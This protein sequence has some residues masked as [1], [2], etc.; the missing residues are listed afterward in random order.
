VHPLSASRC[1]VPALCHLG[2]RSI[3]EPSGTRLARHSGIMPSSPDDRAGLSLHTSFYVASWIFFSNVMI[4]FNKWL[5]DHAGFRY[6]VILTWWHMTFAAV[7]T[8]VLARC[9][10]LL[11]G[12]HNVQMTPKLYFKTVVPIG[13]FYCGSMVSSNLV[14]LYLSVPFIQMLKG[15]APAVILLVGWI[16]GIENPSYTTMAKIAVVIIGVVLSSVGEIRFAWP[17]FL[18]QW[19][20]LG[21]EAGRLILIQTLISSEGHGMDP[22]V[23]LYYT[24]PV[25]AAVNFLISWLV[26]WSRFEWTH[27]VEVG[28]WMLLLNATI[29]F[30]VNVS[31]LLLISKTSSVVY[32][33]TGIS[34]NIMLVMISV[35]IWHTPISPV[36]LVGYVMA[37]LGLLA[38]QSDWQ[39]VRATFKTWS[40]KAEQ[41]VSEKAPVTG[42]PPRR[43]TMFIIVSMFISLLLVVFYT[44]TKRMYDRPPSTTA[45][46]DEAE[47]LSRGWLTWV[48]VVDAKWWIQNG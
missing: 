38:Y 8:Q 39:E 47:R 19:A 42:R 29:A 11:D 48:H 22:L 18:Y 15:A 28:F 36:Q 5:I 34:K 1:P 10:S 32:S 35:A 26:G 23:S 41:T 3:T 33:L 24:A 37:L 21:F 2:P 44:R 6:P 25:C 13:V 45:T 27:A 17:G 9:T 31:S 20:S 12:R 4:L 7:V 30:F 43:P 16:W 14:Y 40:E 46:V